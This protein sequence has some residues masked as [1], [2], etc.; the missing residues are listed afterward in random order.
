[1]EG[2]KKITIGLGDIY[3][4]K[5]KVFAYEIHTHNHYE[6]TLYDSF[7]GAICVNGKTVDTEGGVATLIAPFDFHEIKVEDSLD[8][9]YIKISFSSNV[10]KGNAKNF[11]AILKNPNA[12]GF[13]RALFEEIAN[14]IRNAPYAET[15]IECAIGMF[16]EKGKEILPIHRTTGQKIS[17]DAVAYINDRLSENISLEKAAKH[18]AVTPQYLSRVFKASLGVNFSRYLISVRLRYAE[19]LMQSSENTLT[20]ICFLSGFENFSHFSRSF[21]KQYGVSPRRYRTLLSKKEA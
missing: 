4:E 16:F 20:E 18:L 11:S 6:M 3:A 7:K 2:I 9:N 13:A 8:A 1:M 21:K 19:R 10:P 5:N 12:H 14:N 15:L 17:K